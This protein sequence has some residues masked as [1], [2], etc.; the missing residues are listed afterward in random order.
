MS[1]LINV[2]LLPLLG[3]IIYPPTGA[4]GRRMRALLW[5][6]R[7][8][9]ISMLVYLALAVSRSAL[10]ALGM[11]GLLLIAQR[12][13]RMAWAAAATGGVLVL[14][15]WILWQPLAATLFFSDLLTP[16][17]YPGSSRL[18]IWPFAWGL[19]AKAP[20]TGIGLGAFPG[21]ARAAGLG[22]P[23]T[24]AHAHNLVLQAMLD[25]GIPG[26]LAYLWLVAEAAI[27]AVRAARVSR[28]APEAG[29]AWGL[30]AG[31]LSLALFGLVDAI[32]VTARAGVVVRFVL[33]LC[34]ATR[35]T[36][37]EPPAQSAADIR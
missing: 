14:A 7:A 35:H 20:L 26:A 4:R 15:G 23:E 2:V 22:A 5:A 9:A 12:S 37:A 21:L 27:R 19:L 36:V 3:L 11:A 28:L 30:A 18:A 33:G 1:A 10:L 31:V 25:L 13:R 16:G 8:A 17:T 29:A 32:T 34:A 24:I 6:A